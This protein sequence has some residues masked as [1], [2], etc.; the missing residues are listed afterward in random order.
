[1]VAVT[2][3]GGNLIEVE[4]RVVSRVR[5]PA[6][7]ERS[8]SPLTAAAAVLGDSPSASSGL[9]SVTPLHASD[10]ETQT[11]PSLKNF[12]RFLIDYSNAYR[13][14]LSL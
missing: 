11:P 4:Q 10:A 12:R 8:S 1:M 3:A 6:D 7:N 2:V 5:Q 9:L 14:L 13:L